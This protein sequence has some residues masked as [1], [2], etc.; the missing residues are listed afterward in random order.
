MKNEKT[1][2]IFFLLLKGIIIIYVLYIIIILFLNTFLEET[3]GEIIY[4]EAYQEHL[5]YPN[6]RFSGG[7]LGKDYVEKSIWR[8]EVYYKY[9]VDGIDYKNSRISNVLIF[10]SC[11]FK[12]GDKVTVYYN[13]LMPKYSLIFKC[14]VIYFFIN[15]IPIIILFASI[16]FFEKKN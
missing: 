11:N 7:I 10:P 13:T 1:I 14:N 5:I 4:I 15:F 3:E 2:N 9:T 8:E 12:Y 16:V 6:S